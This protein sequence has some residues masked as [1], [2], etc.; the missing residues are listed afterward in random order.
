MKHQDF[1]RRLFKSRC[2]YAVDDQNKENAMLKLLVILFISVLLGAVG[3]ILGYMIHGLAPMTLLPTLAG[4]AGGFGMGCAGLYIA[5]LRRG[6]A[7]R[8]W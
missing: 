8:R 3:F 2:E 1:C 5:E 7:S 4:A 6:N